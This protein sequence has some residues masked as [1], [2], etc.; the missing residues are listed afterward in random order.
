MRAG[1]V[2]SPSIRLLP[3]LCGMP[4]S[5]SVST[6][7]SKTCGSPPSKSITFAWFADLLTDAGMPARK[8]H[9]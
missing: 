4:K 1:S 8:A 3:M 5:F 7:M 6:A 2:G 9:P